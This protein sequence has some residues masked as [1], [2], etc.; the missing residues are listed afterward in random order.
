M[1]VIVMA[2][3]AWQQGVPA[4]DYRFTSGEYDWLAENPTHDLWGVIRIF[5]TLGSADAM[6]MYMVMGIIVALTLLTSGMLPMWAKL[7]MTA[8]IPAAMVVMLWTM[9]RSAYAALPVGLFAITF[10]TRNR[11]LIIFTVSMAILYVFMSATG[12]GRSNTYVARF[13][14]TTDAQDDE[15][16]QVRQ[17]I[18]DK[19]IGKVFE[20]PI[21]FGP[22]TTGANGAKTLEAAGG[23]QA[24]AELAG[25]ATD[26]Y[27]LR[28]GLEAG[29]L[30]VLTFLLLA[31]CTI[32]SS[33]YCYFKAKSHSARYLLVAIVAVLA[34]MLLGSWANNYFQYPPLTQIFFMSLGLIGPLRDIKEEDLIPAKKAKIYSKFS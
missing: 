1:T 22:N 12:I 11:L 31:L 16:Y 29:W 4:S 28:I 32:L 27:Y 13:F 26:N 18:Q 5:S 8:F 23:D 7:A 20:S 24:D 30:G 10:I 17:A 3:G 21:G 19:T 33:I 15:S 14:T 6:G 25:T 2:Y 9:T 34:A